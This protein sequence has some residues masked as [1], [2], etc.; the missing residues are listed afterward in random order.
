[1]LILRCLWSIRLIMDLVVLIFVGYTFLWSWIWYPS[2]K[3][4]PTSPLKLKCCCQLATN[5][6]MCVIICSYYSNRVH[7]SAAHKTHTLSHWNT[8]PAK[9]HRQWGMYC[10]VAGHV[11][12]KWRSIYQFWSADRNTRIDKTWGPASKSITQHVSADF[13]RSITTPSHCEVS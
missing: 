6:I 9:L 10:I 13:Q 11:L 3:I 8:S 4:L 7:W 12:W 5:N 2:W 1:M